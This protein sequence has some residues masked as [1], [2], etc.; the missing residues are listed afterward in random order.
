MQTFLPYPDF[1]E[2]AKCLDTKR[3]GNQ[4]VEALILLR[5]LLEGNRWSNHPAARMWSGYEGQLKAYAVAICEE[6]ISRGYR[7]TVL[8]KL[9]N[10]ELSSPPPWLGDDRL[11]T[12]HKSNLLRKDFLWYGQYNWPIPPNLPYWWP[13]CRS[14]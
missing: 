3:L 12:S 1:V 8:Q 2:S 4:R 10:L 13:T 5:A 9:P 7:D 6:W 11:H 14:E